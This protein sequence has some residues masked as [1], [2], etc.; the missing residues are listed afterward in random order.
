MNYSK[1]VE[2]LQASPIRK[3]MPFAIK[4]KKEGKTV[5]HLN[6]GQPDI[7]TP[8][9][10][11]EAI[12]QVKDSVIPYQLSN[13]DPLLIE[14]IKT[15]FKKDGLIYHDDEMIITNGGSEALIFSLMA[16]CDPGDEV[17]I[18]EP[19]YTNYSGFM[20]QAG[21]TPVPMITYAE[22]GFHL[23]KK[24]IIEA[25]IT[26]KTKAILFSNPG[27]PTGTVYHKDELEML[28][29]LAL[30]YNLYIIS[31]EVYRKLVFDDEVSISLGE[32]NGIDDRA[33]IIESVS[34]RYSSCGARIGAVVSKNKQLI[35][36]ILKLAQLRLSIS[37][38]DQVGAS[39]LYLL[40]DEYVSSVK[41]EYQRRRDIVME[42]LKKIPNITYKIPKGA[43]YF[44]VTLPID[45]AEN[46]CKW[47]LESYSNQN[48]T[49][50]LAPARDFYVHKELGEK[51]VR[52]AYVLGEEKLKRA[53]EIVKESIEDYNKR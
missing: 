26:D 37:T 39:A 41:N 22:D 42:A 48:E 27:N 28:K 16:I 38:L 11:L 4:A 25:L 20:A 49:V 5:Y 50:M 8:P 7:P 51:Q 40:D 6:I 23:P 24:E 3:L 44:V 19:F 21:A 2:S 46:Y 35:A 53:M 12:N 45:N 34:K 30:K 29:E 15:Y 43:F 32:L 9:C 14:S 47:L 31:D 10:F 33:I 18:P 1:R 13:G 36:H 17:L 52:I